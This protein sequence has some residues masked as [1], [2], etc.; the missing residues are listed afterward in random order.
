VIVRA[1]AIDVASQ[2]VFDNQFRTQAQQSISII[3]VM[4][5]V[6]VLVFLVV[7]IDQLRAAQRQAA[8]H[9]LLTAQQRAKKHNCSARVS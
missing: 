8:A 4:V 6:R 7:R 3:L 9:D 2:S 1:H 5:V